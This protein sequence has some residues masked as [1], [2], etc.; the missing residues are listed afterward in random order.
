MNCLRV[1]AQA[2]CLVGRRSDCHCVHWG[3]RERLRLSQQSNAPFSLSS[4]L[5]VNCLVEECSY[6]SNLHLKLEAVTPLLLG[7]LVLGNVTVWHCD[8]ATVRHRAAAWVVIIIWRFC[9][10]WK[11]FKYLVTSHPVTQHGV[12]DV[13]DLQQCHWENMKFWRW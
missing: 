10:P 6:D 3:H 8:R 9:D 12:P 5:Q 13:C 11:P 2:P 7:V 1:W 4:S